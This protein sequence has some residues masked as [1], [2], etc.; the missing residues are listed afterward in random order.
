MCIRDRHRT[1]EVLGQMGLERRKLAQEVGLRSWTDADI[2]VL[3]QPGTL[4]HFSGAARSTWMHAIRAGVAV[5]TAN[6]DVPCD[7]WGA[8]DYLLQRNQQRF[9]IV[10]AFG[11]GQAGGG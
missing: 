7:W 10:V 11:E 8:S 4:L 5:P 3:V 9:S 2:D 6:G 1:D